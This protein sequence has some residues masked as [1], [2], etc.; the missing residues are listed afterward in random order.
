MQLKT[1]AA[2]AAILM[3][4]GLGLAA[5]N[6]GTE[7]ADRPAAD[8]RVASADVH[9]FMIGTLEAWALRDGGLEAPN[10]GSVL[11]MGE[12]KAEVDALLTAAG[13]P[14]DPLSLSIQPMLLKTGDRVV[15]FDSG[16][17]AAFG[18]AAGKLAASLAT[19]GVTSDQITDVLISHSHGDHVGG[20][21]TADGALAYPNATI[22]MSAE[23]W[24]ALQASGEMAD[25]VAAIAPK[26]ETFAD[27]AE[28]LPGVTAVPI[29]G[30]TPG[31]TAFEVTSGED[32]LLSIGDT[33]HHHVISVQRPDWTIQ[34]DGKPEMAEASRAALWERAADEDL[35]L[36]AVHFP[37]P[38]IGHVRRQGETFVWEA[39]GAASHQA[40]H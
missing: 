37:W 26:V 27:G 18:E 15:L 31:H 5:C 14:T 32:R 19:A 39:E 6:P 11:A 12:P 35:R 25:L 1:T 40:Q 36:Y 9:P 8:S 33:A 29:D 4:A 23:E 20:L 22:R 10:D 7:P 28:V 13:V 2:M 16:A 38:G 24:A 34:F 3:S 21:V 17:G 30:H